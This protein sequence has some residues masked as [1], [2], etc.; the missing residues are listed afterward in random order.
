LGASSKTNFRERC[1]ETWQ[2]NAATLESRELEEA[3]LQCETIQNEVL[4]LDCD[5]LRALY[6]P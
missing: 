5:T 4:E 1:Q 6:M 3:L 2:R